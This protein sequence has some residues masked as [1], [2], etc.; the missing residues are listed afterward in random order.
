VTVAAPKHP[1]ILPF[2]VMCAG[3][4]MALLDIQ[5]VASSLQ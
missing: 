3:M 4:F 2:V 5:I 1:A